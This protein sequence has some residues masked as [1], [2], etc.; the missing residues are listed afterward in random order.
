MIL[1]SQDWENTILVLGLVNLVIGVLCGSLWL[2][3]SRLKIARD[4]P[5]SVR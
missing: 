1:I 3:I 2:L 5:D 4:V